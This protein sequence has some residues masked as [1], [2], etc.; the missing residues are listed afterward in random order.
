[1]NNKIL[2]LLGLATRARNIV[3]GDNAVENALK[4]K[5]VKMLIISE[6]ASDKTKKN[7]KFYANKY[8]ITI[9]FMGKIDEL[10]NAIGEKN[11]AIIGIKD[12]NIVKGIEKIIDG[13]EAIG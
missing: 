1:M 7:Y 9:I 8:N 2:N 6:E 11:R 12:I 5:K 13:G 10:S 3:S 4:L